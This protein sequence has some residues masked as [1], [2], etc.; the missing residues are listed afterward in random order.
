[1]TVV[2]D[3]K[4]PEAVHEEVRHGR[5]DLGILSYPH[6]WPGVAAIPLRDEPM[7]LV[8]PPQHPLAR[9]DKVQVSQLAKWPLVT[10][11]PE[12]PVGRHIRRYLRQNGVLATI[13]N[14]F[15]NIDT[16]EAAVVAT[17]GA[18]ILP[19][20]TVQG[21]VAA[22][23]LAAVDLDPP[24]A[25]PMGIIHTR[26]GTSGFP[27]VIQGFVDC[28]LERAGPEEDEGATAEA[29]DRQSVGADK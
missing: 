26:R 1:M 9:H 21:E 7:A 16:I 22:G 19:G 27:P 13:D 24:L 8:C 11:E 6:R 25:R 12:L 20:R 17:G 15:D 5:C 3:Y 14:V 28:L 2:V 29:G 23:T 10:F 18:S 4:R